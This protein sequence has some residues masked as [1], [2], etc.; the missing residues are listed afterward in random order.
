MKT[1]TLRRVI[2]A[3]VLLY[4]SMSMALPSKDKMVSNVDYLTTLISYSY[5]PQ[6]WKQSH[7]GWSLQAEANKVK[8][9]IMSS[10]ST[11]LQDYQKIVSQLFVSTRDYHVGFGFTST[12]KASLP[13]SVKTIEGKVIIVHI[14]RLLLPASTFSA[15]VGDEIV[16]WNGLPIQQEYSQLMNANYINTYVTDLAWADLLLTRRSASSA[17]QVPQGQ[18]VIGTRNLKTSAFINS[19]LAWSYEADIAG[20]IPDHGAPLA[21][22]PKATLKKAFTQYQLSNPTH[23]SMMQMQ[24]ADNGENH[25]ALG[26]KKSFVPELGPILWSAETDNEFNAYIFE[27]N[28][29]KMGY[30]RISSYV[31]TNGSE[32]AALA[33]ET[34]VQKFEAETEGLIIDEVNNPGGS[35][36]YLYSLVALLTQAPAHAPHH[37]MILNQKTILDA[38]STLQALNMIQTEEDITKLI[39]SNSLEGY[40]IDMDFINLMKSYLQFMISEWQKGKVLTDAYHL[41]GVDKI[42]PNPRVT[43]SKPIFI[44][45]NE[46]DFSGG[47]FFPA[48]M[49][50]N[51]RAYIIGNR[52]A[53]AGGY[54][55]SYEVPNILGLSYFSLTASI[56]E[57]IDLNP[58]ENL[59]VT[60]D[61][62]VDVTLADIDNGFASYKQK[63]L[64][65]VKSKIP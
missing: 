55:E 15:E 54:V 38:H 7:F 63:V 20:D 49:Q 19:S 32:T 23:I 43:Y 21:A 48:I 29:K 62:Q 65:F 47:D 22:S 12:E 37:K 58:I 41:Y 2:I 17:L 61:L 64:D 56:A 8:Q 45:T 10:S 30:I 4:I 18:V 36:L 13:F 14:D 27:S 11:R 5:G 33:F 59:G 35:V 26:Q 34:I 28:G 51:K 6:Y 44:L 24:A 53:G 1:D 9:E 42:K 52:T 60:P 40:T 25:F 16:T 31:P 46:L 39:G 57:R 50:D 3:L